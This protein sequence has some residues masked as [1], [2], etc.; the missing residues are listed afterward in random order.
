MVLPTAKFSLILPRRPRELRCRSYIILIFIQLEAPVHAM[1]KAFIP[2][3]L[4]FDERA[5]VNT[6]LTA[7]DVQEGVPAASYL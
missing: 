5:R 1:T 6:A 4:L 7:D 2:H 3:D